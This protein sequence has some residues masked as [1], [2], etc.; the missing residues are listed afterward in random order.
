MLQYADEGNPI[1]IVLANFAQSN[2][3][4]EGTASNESFEINLPVSTH[5]P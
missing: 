3:S 2:A 5:T 1:A 4:Y